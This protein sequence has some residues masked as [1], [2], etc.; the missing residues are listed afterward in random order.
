MSRALLFGVL[1]LMVPL[2]LAR[3]A[4]ATQPAGD[5]GVVQP[6][7]TP[8]QPPPSTPPPQYQPQPQYQ[9][10]PQYQG[11][12][13]YQP[14]PPVQYQYQPKPP[15]PAPSKHWEEGDAVPE[16]YH[17][18]E[19]PRQG[20]V[21][22]G[23][24]LILVPYAISALTAVGAKGDN[25]TNWLFAPVAGPW[26]LM[27]RR[28]YACCSNSATSSDSGLGCVADVFVVTG[29]IVDGI[30]QATGATLL[31]LGYL[32]TKPA[33]VRDERALRI[34]PMRIGNGYGAGLG[35]MF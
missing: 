25:E 28:H 2:A 17:V 13:Q 16:G 12:P 26:F 14:A 10:P 24:V 8:T 3:H 23:F 31:L 5:I 11:Q 21:V 33:L 29:L 6:Q 9:P 19:R 20:L 30:L 34:R 22:G 15:P 32:N 18:E 4:H 1:A 35:A 7:G 27:G